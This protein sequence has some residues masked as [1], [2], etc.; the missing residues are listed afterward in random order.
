MLKFGKYKGKTYEHVYKTDKNYCAW[1]VENCKSCKPFKTFILEKGLFNR[2]S[3]VGKTT[4]ASELA[5]KISLDPEIRLFVT[6]LWEAELDSMELESLSP[7]EEP[8]EDSTPVDLEENSTPVDLDDPAYKPLPGAI[9]KPKKNI[10]PQL[11]GQFI[12]Y[13]I[14]YQLSVHQDIEFKDRATMTIIKRQLA[15]WEVVH[16]AMEMLNDPG[17][18]LGGTPGVSPA[19]P[20]PSPVERPSPLIFHNLLR[21]AAAHPKA[22]GG[23]SSTTLKSTR[24]ML[25]LDD[26]IIARVNDFVKQVVSIAD[27]KKVKIMQNPCIS[28]SYISADADLIYGDTIVDF[29]T[30]RDDFVYY[31]VQLLVYAA[32]YRDL[33]E[34]EPKKLLIFNPCMEEHT[35]TLN[36]KSGVLDRFSDYLKKLKILWSKCRIVLTLS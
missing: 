16:K 13:F 34:I 7:E 4:T 15:G 2:A 3:L 12:D 11:Y 28:G 1:F 18:T 6:E 23:R 30:G 25:E 24:V 5:K 14:R 35:V 29:K 36:L 19:S 20:S 8:E 10:T 31:T 27:A 32:L 21:C 33:Y 26:D 17:I 22:Y 9:A